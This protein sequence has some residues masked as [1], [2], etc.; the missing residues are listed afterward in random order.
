MQRFAVL[1]L[2]LVAT[3]P[4]ARIGK[5]SHECILSCVPLRNFE[6]REHRLWIDLLFFSFLALLFF[7]CEF[8]KLSNPK[9]LAPN[10]CSSSASATETECKFTQP[11]TSAE[12]EAHRSLD[13]L[14]GVFGLQGRFFH[15]S[16]PGSL[17]TKKGKAFLSWLEDHAVAGW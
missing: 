4:P 12:V 7:L 16:P 13:R 11:I 17:C 6:P 1:L 2:E 8:L 10:C 9:M 3:R 14:C 15:R 5:H